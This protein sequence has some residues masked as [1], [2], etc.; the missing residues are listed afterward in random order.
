MSTLKILIAT[1]LNKILFNDDTYMPIQVGK[2]LS[3]TDLDIQGDD[4]GDNISIKNPY[5]CELTAIYWAWKNLK[6]TDYIGLCHYR[7]YFD[8]HG[9]CKKGFPCTVFPTSDCSKKNLSITEQ[10][11]KELENGYTIVPKSMNL[12]FSL[13]N[14][15]CMFH[16]S[17]DANILKRVIENSCEKK[18]ADAFDEVMYRS[19]K[20]RPYNMFIMKWDEFDRYCKWLFSILEK[21]EKEIDIK[22]RTSY[23]KRIFG[24]MAERMLNIYIYAERLKTVD[25]PILLFNDTPDEELDMPYYRYKYKNA[26]RNIYFMFSVSPKYWLKMLFHKQI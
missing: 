21:V 17:E 23:Q 9:Q 3:D 16:I 12:K 1:H 6:G 26:L 24:F 19:H 8:F 4:T 15:Y 7:R 2:S 5:Y 10:A 22:N 11:I 14:H 20:L 25:Y 18:Y 13:F